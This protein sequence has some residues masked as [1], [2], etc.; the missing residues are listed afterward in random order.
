MISFC[1][2]S[3]SSAF[4]ASQKRDEMTRE[5]ERRMRAIKTVIFSQSDKFPPFNVMGVGERGTNTQSKNK[6]Q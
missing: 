1:W 6:T 5:W 3:K 2:F 4:T